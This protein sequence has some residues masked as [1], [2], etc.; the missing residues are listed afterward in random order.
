MTSARK[1][2]FLDHQGP[3]PIAHRGGAAEKPQNTIAAFTHARS[4]GYRHIETDVHATRDHQLAVFHDDHLEPSTDSTGALSD[5][6]MDEIRRARAQGEPIP[7]I[8]EVF[9]AFPDAF[10]NIEPKNDA[11][12][13][14][15]A[16]AITAAGALDRVCIGSFKGRRLRKM[17]K[18]LGP[19]LCTSGG[20][21]VI[22]RLRV[23]GWLG[24]WAAGPSW[25]LPPVIQVPVKYGPIPVADK[26]FVRAAHK[27]GI[28]VHVWTI[29]DAPTMNRL[30]DLG[31][32][33]IMT[34][35]PTV[36]KDVL[37]SRGAWP[38]G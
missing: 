32:D 7:T 24:A 13:E 6:T 9:A 19:R 29:D 2:P 25:G 33:G 35:R 23:A 16:N 22:V 36:L 21:F 3:M 30:L 14:L 27:R 1:F 26:G 11:S 12:V 31:V 17:R 4:L 15:L 37:I 18:L 38:A 10:L 20:P 5:L 34:D 8:E 28:D